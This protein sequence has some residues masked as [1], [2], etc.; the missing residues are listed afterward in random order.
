MKNQITIVLCVF[1]M[2]TNNF[3]S[4]AQNFDSNLA[5]LTLD[6]NNVVGNKP[7]KL[8]DES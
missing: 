2:L 6:F 8:Q 5:K 1:A 3:A 7:L 4:Y